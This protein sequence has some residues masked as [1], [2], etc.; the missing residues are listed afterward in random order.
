[1]Q[2]PSHDLAVEIS[3]LLFFGGLSVA[4]SLQTLKAVG[5]THVVNCIG[6]VQKSAF[7]CTF[8]YMTLAING[9]HTPAPQSLRHPAAARV[10]D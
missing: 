3:V 10:P 7:P 1:M 6:H 8:K 9:G 4:N 5:I 2:M